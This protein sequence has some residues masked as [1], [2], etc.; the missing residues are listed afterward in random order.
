[1]TTETT[2]QGPEIEN[3]LE[4]LGFDEDADPERAA[5]EAAA[6]AS[7]VVTPAVDPAKAALADAIASAG[8]NGT[9]PASSAVVTPVVEIPPPVAVAEPEPPAALPDAPPLVPPPKPLK[10]TTRAAGAASKLGK[11]LSDKVGSSERIKVWKREENGEVWYINDHG[12]QDLVGFSDMEAFLQRYYLKPHGAGE[13]LLMGI[14]AQGR[15]IQ[16][17]PV[18]LRGLPVETPDN[19][20]A[21][22]VTTILDRSAQ[23][24]QQFLDKMAGLN[25]NAPPQQSPMGLLT[26]VMTL[27]KQVTG[28]A[29]E[30]TRANDAAAVQQN[31][32]AMEALSS[33]GDRT[34]QMMMAM[35]QQAQSS[36]DRQNT[37]MMTLL[38]KPPQEDP[39]MKI[40]LLKLTEDNS[41]GGALPP[42]PPPPASP[43]A[44]LVEIMTAMASFMGAMG[45]GGGDSEGDEHKQFLQQLV[46]QKQ[47]DGLGTKE[48]IELLLQKDNKPGTDD[49]RSA[50][51]NMA[52]I[53]N[54]ATNVNRQQEGGPAA[55]FFD[56]LGALFSNRDFAGSIA[57]SIRQKVGGEG[58]QQR[59]AMQRKLVL[60]QQQLQLQQAQQAQQIPAGV[61]PPPPPPYAQVVQQVPAGAQPAQ[62]QQGPVPPQAGAPAPH[63]ATPQQVQQAAANV[64][65]RTGGLPQLPAETPDHINGLM[66]AEDEPELVGRTIRMFI[67]FAGF[68]DWRP[69][70]EKLLDHI[71]TGNKQGTLHFIQSFFEGLAQ[72]KMI[73]PNLGRAIVIGVTKHF[74]VVEKEL[75]GIGLAND[76]TITGAS[77]LD[78][79]GAAVETPATQQRPPLGAPVITPPPTEAAVETPATDAGPTEDD[80]ALTALADETQEGDGEPEP[81]T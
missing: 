23:Q 7:T 47:T 55:G 80:G 19:S 41:G 81:V 72:I 64:Q 66:L 9:P 37:M 73:D 2:P 18:R 67:Y 63:H 24:N 57:Q 32:A 16:L 61:I 60:Q 75:A 68:D 5:Q 12:K 49:F 8:D 25:S 13:Y 22:L 35:M 71:R 14:D 48:V 36:A 77:L 52:Q 58:L 53:M 56:A 59:Q 51:D 4:R 46:L 54:I 10:A 39:V 30:K 43:T 79:D 28:E 3:T 45:G 65:A 50:V 34:M 42:P 62:V 20:M 11:G 21:S 26:E 15:E 69:F 17:A 6:A 76:E 40:L 31:N 74:D 70:M 44:G 78:P 1:M 38:S 29:E 27:Q 33:S